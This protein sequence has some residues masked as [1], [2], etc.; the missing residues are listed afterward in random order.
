M[1]ISTEFAQLLGHL[2]CH[3]QIL[4]V[5]QIQRCEDELVSFKDALTQ[6]K[7]SPH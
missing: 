4:M 3:C 1:L 7:H 6:F 5:T 2:L